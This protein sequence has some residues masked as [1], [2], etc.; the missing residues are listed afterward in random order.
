MLK[1]LTANRGNLDWGTT[2]YFHY[3]RCDR[4]RGMKV[5][6]A[7]GAGFIGSHVTQ[8]LVQAGHQATVLDNLSAGKFELVPPQAGFILGDLKDEASLP[9]WLEGHDVVI[10]LAALVPV[11]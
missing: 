9:G 11:A 10:H 5:F 7:G 4:M 2:A 6:V 8:A 1:R 3:G